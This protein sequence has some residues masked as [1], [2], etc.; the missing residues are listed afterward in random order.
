MDAADARVEVEAVYRE[1]LPL[2]SRLRSAVTNW[3][4]RP[5]D[6]DP[7]AVNRHRD[8][9]WDARIVAELAALARDLRPLIRALEARLPRFSGYDRRFSSAASR[10][11]DG[12]RA[13]VDVIE[14]DSCHTVWFELH[15][16]LLATLGLQR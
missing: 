16:D 1:F 3:Q 9:V 4:I 8:A 11:Q 5:T 2:N 10:V 7:F 13:W 14:L 15:E 6:D 12:E